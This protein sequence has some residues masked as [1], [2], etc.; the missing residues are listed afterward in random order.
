[1][2][3]NQNTKPR[4]QILRMLSQDS[5]V[6]ESQNMKPKRKQK[7]SLLHWTDNAVVGSPYHAIFRNL[8][9]NVDYTIKLSFIMAGHTLGV[10]SF[11]IAA[12]NRKLSSST[13]SSSVFPASR[14]VSDA[15][16]S[17][18]TI[19]DYIDDDPESPVIV[20]ESQDNFEKFMNGMNYIF[21]LNVE[22]HC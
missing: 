14:K 18:S 6:V 11:T 15:S 5:S 20:A 21:T 22:N 1:M 17:E 4:L 19:N 9:V 10:V 16:S 13:V 2:V 12:E 8:R 7:K 3:E